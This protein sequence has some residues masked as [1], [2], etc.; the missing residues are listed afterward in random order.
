MMTNFL[1]LSTYGT[2]ISGATMRR[3]AE[4]G[5][6][7]AGALLTP[8]EALAVLS[9]PQ[10]A[11]TPSLEREIMKGMSAEP[12]P[13]SRARQ[14]DCHKQP[15]PLRAA[16]DATHHTSPGTPV[17]GARQGILA[18]LFRLLCRALPRVSIAA[19]AAAT[20]RLGEREQCQSHAQHEL[21]HAEE[22]VRRLRQALDK[23]QHRAAEA[24]KRLRS[25]DG[26]RHDR[27]VE[28]DCE[29]AADTG[30]A[31]DL[32]YPDEICPDPRWPD[33]SS[34]LE[35]WVEAARQNIP[36]SSE[37]ANTYSADSDKYSNKSVI[38]LPHGER[39]WSPC[40]E[41]KGHEDVCHQG[42]ADRFIRARSDLSVGTH[43]SIL[44][45]ASSLDSQPVPQRRLTTSRVT[46]HP[47][48]ATIAMQSEPAVTLPCPNRALQT[49]H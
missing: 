6:T 2:R 24:R 13:D 31:H 4:P 15:S 29:D 39:P 38:V 14:P 17:A 30:E 23:T 18:S 27:R 45:A 8:D 41:T 34:S 48:T 16:A 44:S 22:D 43:E 3:E 32:Q 5:T 21:N 49:K 36:N 37:T 35:R 10:T 26:I 11:Q 12:A 19:A 9:Q 7:R 46:L 1:R 28:S 20:A 33:R 47:R 42:Q 25:M 40:G